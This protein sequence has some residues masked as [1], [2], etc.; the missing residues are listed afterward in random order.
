MDDYYSDLFSVYESDTEIAQTT[1]EVTSDDTEILESS[2]VDQEPEAVYTFDGRDY[3]R[4]LGN[5]DIATPPFKRNDRDLLGAGRAEKT[6]ISQAQNTKEEAQS[7]RA[8][9]GALPSFDFKTLALAGALL[10][11]AVLSAQS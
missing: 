7:Q 9:V 11:F 10:G 8:A 6:P 4:L 5:Y 1:F 2:G 3:T